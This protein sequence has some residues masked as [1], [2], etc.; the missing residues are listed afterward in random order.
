MVQ[1]RICKYL[2]HPEE[3]YT[4]TGGSVAGKLD[5]KPSDP[6][7]IELCTWLEKFDTI[8]TSLRMAGGGISIRDGDCTKCPCF[9][10]VEVPPFPK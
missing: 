10:P 5:L 1:T 6:F 3:A 9:E 7:E 8:P 4:L 2:K